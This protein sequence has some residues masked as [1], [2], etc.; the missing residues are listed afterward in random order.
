M[1]LFCF[2]FSYFVLGNEIGLEYLNRKKAILNL[3]YMYFNFYT[4]RS[5]YNAGISVNNIVFGSFP[6][7]PAKFQYYTNFNMTNCE[8]RDF[9][10]QLKDFRDSQI[11]SIINTYHIDIRDLKINNVTYTITELV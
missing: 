1:K 11:F 9:E 5:D 3:T 4:H 6:N 10:Y 2:V 8:F 7:K